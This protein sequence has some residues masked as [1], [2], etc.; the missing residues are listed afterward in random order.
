M[1]KF[2]TKQNCA[3]DLQTEASIVLA[4]A[5]R[6]SYSQFP[7]PFGLVTNGKSCWQLIKLFFLWMILS[8]SKMELEKLN[9]ESGDTTRNVYALYGTQFGSTAILVLLVWKDRLLRRKILYVT[10]IIMGVLLF[11]ISLGVF[12]MAIFNPHIP[13]IIIQS[14][15]IVGL[16]IVNIGITTIFI[17]TAEAGPT[18]VRTSYI[19]ICFV[20]F[21]LGPFIAAGF[22]VVD[23]QPDPRLTSIPYF[24]YALCLFAGAYLW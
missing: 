4:E 2:A 11:F 10:F 15:T 12:L 6:V 23:S 22:D 19:G 17:Y 1:K 24:F 21:N 13:S 3:L 7:V 18:V 20:G 5:S 14:A 8:I 16:V 9:F